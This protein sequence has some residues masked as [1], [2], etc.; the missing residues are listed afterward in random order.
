MSEYPNIKIYVPFDY[1]HIMS[2]LILKI[3]IQDTEKLTGIL[4]FV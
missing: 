1:T 3:N 2:L 4:F